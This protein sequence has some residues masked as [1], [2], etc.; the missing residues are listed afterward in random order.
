MLIKEIRIL[1]RKE[2]ILEWR[3]RYALNGMLLYVGST[4]FICYMSF[5]I[6]MSQLNVITWNALFWIVMLFNAV[7]AIA[8]SFMQEREERQLYYYTLVSPQSIIVAKTIYNVFLMFSLTILAYLVYS[9]VLG[10]KVEDQLLFG[11][12]MFLGALG[13]SVSLTMV[14]SIAAKASNNTTLMAILSFPVILPIILMVIKISKN[15]IDGIERSESYNEI[16]TLLAINVIIGAV[17][18]LLF[19]YIWRS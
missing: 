10:N 11:V 9:L 13:F 19:P 16:I 12:G 7:N 17:S 6:N 18:Y 4:I 8:K 3:Q 14:S 5:N 1:L 15:A 2:F